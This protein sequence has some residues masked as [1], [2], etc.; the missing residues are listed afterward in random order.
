MTGS[1]DHNIT[2]FHFYIKKYKIKIYNQYYIIYNAKKNI[3]AYFFQEIYNIY[4][5]IYLSIILDNNN[6]KL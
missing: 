4:L 3:I 1:R 2:I 6:L 5:T